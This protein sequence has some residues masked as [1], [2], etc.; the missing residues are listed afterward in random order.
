[1]I[2][3]VVIWYRY[4]GFWRRGD[5]DGND[6]P[7]DHD[8]GSEDLIWNSLTKE[9]YELR[10]KI[11]TTEEKQ[12]AVN[13]FFKCCDLLNERKRYP[14]EFLTGYEAPNMLVYWWRKYNKK[15]FYKPQKRMSRDPFIALGMFYAFLMYKL[16]DPSIE[17]VL[18]AEF[19]K[20]TI[21]FHLR[22]AFITLRWWRR[23]KRD[24]R[25]EYVI[26]LEDRKALGT[27]YTYLRRFKDDFYENMEE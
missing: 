14:D 7:T 5:A 27:H 22:Y 25:K 11:P 9:E 13:L 12:L 18:Q 23:L 26:R 2:Q 8:D 3:R 20:V 24:N 15:L 17:V 6:L 1:M 4:K 19:N 21:P 16:D 10:K